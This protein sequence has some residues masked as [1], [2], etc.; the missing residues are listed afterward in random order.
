MTYCFHV[1]QYKL[2]IPCRRD[3]FKF[4]GA[5]ARHYL[6]YDK[7]IALQLLY[8]N[9]TPLQGKEEIFGSNLLVP[10]PIIVYVLIVINPIKKIG[11]YYL[12]KSIVGDM[13]FV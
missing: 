6:G 2:S 8:A 3:D 1:Q 5:R 10:K 9:H 13:M 12:D 7:P 4:T 11:D